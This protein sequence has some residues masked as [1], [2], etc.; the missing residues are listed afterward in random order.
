MDY[1]ASY[2]GNNSG[3]QYGYDF[4]TGQ[5]GYGQIGANGQFSM[6][7]AKSGTGSGQTPAQ[8]IQDIITRGTNAVPDSLKDLSK[9][10]TNTLTSTAGVSGKVQGAADQTAD[11]ISSLVG[12]GNPDYTGQ[13]VA[14]ISPEE[15]ASKDALAAQLSRGGGPGADAMKGAVG[16]KTDT[17]GITGAAGPVDTQKLTDVDISKYM[18]PAMT[19]EYDQILR[20]GDIQKNAIR[21]R[22]AKAG[23]F[24]ENSAVAQNLA[25][26]TTQR[27]LGLAS[28]DA[29]RT[30]QGAAQG[31][32]SAENVGRQANRTAAMGAQ[33]SKLSANL[34]DAQRALMGGSMMNSDFQSLAGATAGAGA[35]A[36]GITQAGLDAKWQQYLQKL[37][38][39]TTLAGAAS[40]AL[41]GLPGTKT[42]SQEQ[43]GPS[44]AGQQIGALIGLT[45]IQNQYNKPG[46][47]GG[48]ISYSPYTPPSL[49]STPAGG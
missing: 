31:D 12:Q 24:G 11:Y 37:G 42:L 5:W 13:R 8:V 43:L 48:N 7:G 35:N 41:A 6:G 2:P 9:L 27:Q 34:T 22:Q 3:Q 4:N 15:Q 49:N 39:G 26:E 20:G 14:G 21:A 47:A 30:A 29:F 38:Y 10:S 19:A 36:R 17:S 32:V 25:D 16:Q 1:G 28:S 44:D 18:N 45:G 46:V 33:T 23:A 40:G